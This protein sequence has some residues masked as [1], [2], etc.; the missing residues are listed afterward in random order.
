MKNHQM[1]KI[2]GDPGH[3]PLLDVAMAWLRHQRR[4]AP[5]HSDVWHLRHHWERI[6]P[7]LQQQLQTGT[8]QLTPMQVVGLDR[9]AMW[10]SQDALVLKWVALQVTPLLPVHPRCEHVKGHGGGRASIA[11]LSTALQSGEYLYV[12]RTDIKG[13]YG[14][15]TKKTVMEQVRRYVADP[16]LLGLID[17]YLHYT[18]EQ[19]GEFYTPAKGICRGCPLSPLI[20]A[21]HLYEVDAHFAREQ[22]TRGIVYARY[23]DDFIILAKSRWQLRGQ[24]KALNSY[25]Q[26]YGF[27][28]HPDKTF[29]GRIGKGF[30]WLGAWLGTE[31]VEDIAP[32]ALANHRE[33]VRRLYE[34]F[35][36]K[37]KAWVHA[38]VSQYRSRWK[39]WAAWL[40]AVSACTPIMAYAG[41]NTYAVTSEDLKPCTP[42]KVLTWTS[43]APYQFSGYYHSGGV[44]YASPWGGGTAP[45]G[46]VTHTYTSPSISADNTGITAWGACLGLGTLYGAVN[47]ASSAGLFAQLDTG[48]TVAQLTTQTDGKQHSYSIGGRGQS[49]FYSLDPSVFSFLESVGQHVSFTYQWPS[50]IKA[51]QGYDNPPGPAL[52]RA[53]VT[54]H[55]DIYLVWDG[56]LTGPDGSFLSLPAGT[57]YGANLHSLSQGDIGL[58][59]SPAVPIVLVPSTPACS[60]LINGEIHPSSTSIPLGE[61]DPGGCAGSQCPSLTRTISGARTA[62]QVSC[63]DPGH[64]P[65][66]DHTDIKPIVSVLGDANSARSKWLLRTSLGDALTVWGTTVAGDSWGCNFKGWTT[67]DHD[68]SHGGVPYLGG[69][70]WVPFPTDGADYGVN[71]PWG[72]TRTGWISDLWTS[73]TATIQWGVCVDPAAGPIVSGPFTASATIAL[74]VP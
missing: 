60:L 63:S 2:A 23:M 61:I 52:Y 35:W 14:A 70:V 39:I 27:I 45:A 16:V 51:G 19:G 20:G 64:R 34:R 56:R 24:V 8:Y 7:V 42:V 12:C 72:S 46:A 57:F 47:S 11:R 74:S 10:S 25:L 4:N 6:A 32:R 17:Q 67:G 38:R 30:D 71:S 33:K 9:N 21:M 59:P 5:V 29:I 13:Y 1:Q 69:T 22:E 40:L 49:G 62:V 41:W 55:V 50:W 31:G 73:K 68:P 58:E 37:P 54:Q 26:A 53:N 15:I 36:R 44:R 66:W 43:N 65:G 3:L 48:R 28:Q 18:V